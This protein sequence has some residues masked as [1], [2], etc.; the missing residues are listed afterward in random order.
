MVPE[1]PPVLLLTRLWLLHSRAPRRKTGSSSLPPG[2]KGFDGFRDRFLY[3]RPRDR[4]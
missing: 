4:E 3:E 1:Y 2:R